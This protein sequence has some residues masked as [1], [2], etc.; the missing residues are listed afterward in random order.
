MKRF[1]L[2]VL[3]G[4]STF[5][6]A[7][8][9]PYFK[10]YEQRKKSYEVENLPHLQAKFSTVYFGLSEGLT[11]PRYLHSEQ[12]DDFAKNYATIK[13]RE[14]VNIGFNLDNVHF[15]ESGINRWKN[16]YNLLIFGTNA[17]PDF[18]LSVDNQQWFIPVVYK[19]RIVRLNRVTQNAAL[20]WA[21]GGG[22]E[23]ARNPKTKVEW[24]EDIQS[25]IKSPYLDH[26]KVEL[27]QKESKWYIE[28]GP[29]IRGNVTER[30]ELLVYFKALIRDKDYLSNHFE[31]QLLNSSSPKQFYIK[32]L[33]LSFA[34]GLQARLNSK[35]FF[36][37]SS[38]I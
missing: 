20:N 28:T 27:K 29:E 34:F 33:P 10:S 36:R 16:V 21:V 4:I 17:Y 12:F 19:R 13:T 22:I 26:F 15:F 37:Y 3:I 1:L 23:V 18:R 32:E 8:D 7:Q 30:L 5:V 14:E 24:V 38:I 35:K 9:E 31:Y 2:C 25:F 6:E 11:K